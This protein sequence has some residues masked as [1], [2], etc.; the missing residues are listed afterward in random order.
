MDEGRLL[1]SDRVSLACRSWRCPDPPRA[2][3]VLVHG[4]CSGAEDPD[5]VA[6][7]DA[8]AEAGLDVISYDGRGHGASAGLCTLGDDERH[9]VAAAV[10]LARLRSSRVV[11]VGASMGAIA[12][13]RHA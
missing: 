2:A 8:M 12:V 10:E 3:V 7:A 5:V 11:V 13:L 1:T 9:D 6:V 4:F